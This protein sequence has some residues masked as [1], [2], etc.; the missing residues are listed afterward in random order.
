MGPELLTKLNQPMKLALTTICVSDAVSFA[1]RWSSD[2]RV[3][4]LPML[5]PAQVFA[6]QWSE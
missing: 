1:G 4:M 2:H 6:A 5:V 3:R